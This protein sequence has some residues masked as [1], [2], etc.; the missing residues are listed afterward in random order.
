MTQTAQKYTEHD[1]DQAK[2]ILDSIGLVDTDNDGVRN[3]TDGKGDLVFITDY[4]A[5]YFVAYDVL[6]ELIEEDLAKVGVKLAL[7]PMDVSLF[8][9]RR[10]GNTGIM[11]AGGVGG[12]TGGR[13]CSTDGTSIRKRVPHVVHGR[14]G[15]LLRGLHSGR[16][17]RPQH[18]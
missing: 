1:P 18:P 8:K 12:R 16:A 4:A 9:E 15:C 10:D 14:Q 13:P 3:R 2:Q 17:D 6:A 5:E 7:K 11:M